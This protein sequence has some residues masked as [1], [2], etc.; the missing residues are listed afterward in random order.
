MADM[1]KKGR[2]SRGERHRLRLHPELV[3]RGEKN[4]LAKLRDV[5]VVEIHRLL[6]E[7][8][9]SGRKIGQQFGVSRSTIERIRDGKGWT[10]VPIPVPK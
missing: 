1:A 8:E 7:G 10:H 9:L 3:Q 6:R 2:A 4:G 5:D